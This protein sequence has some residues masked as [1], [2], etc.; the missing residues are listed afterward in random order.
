MKIQKFKNLLTQGALACILL[1]LSPAYAQQTYTVTT[2]IDT[3]PATTGSLRWAIEQVN[4]GAGQGDTIDFKIPKTDAG[5]DP[6]T[7]TW[8]IV[9]IQ[10]LDAITQQVTIDGYSQKAGSK[11]NTLDVGSNAVLTIVLNGNN[12]MT[13]DGNTTGNGLHFAPL[14]DTSVDNSIVRGLVINQWLDNGI[15]LD[16][17][18]NN[19][20]GVSI[21]GNFIGTDAS[22]AQQMA[23][24]TGVG[25]SGLVNTCFNTVIGTIAPAD[26]NIIAGSFSRNVVDAYG[27]RGGCISSS[28]NVETMIQN[29]YIGTD[30]TGSNAL[31]NT[32]VGVRLI[33]DVGDTIFGNLISGSTI[34]GIFLINCGQTLVQRNYIGTDSSGTYAIGN[35]NSG[36]RMARSLPAGATQ[37]T[38]MIEN[39]ISG[40]GAGIHIGDPGNPGSILN[41]IQGNLIGTDK[42]GTQALPNTRYG[43]ELADSQNTV[44]GSE[45]T[46]I[47]IIS[48]NL[49]GGI[50][51][52]SNNAIAN[53]ISNNLIGTDSTGLLSL[54]NNQNGIQI[55]LNGGLGGA[56]RN[57]IG[58]DPSSQSALKKNRIDLNAFQK[59]KAEHMYELPHRSRKR[60]KLKGSYTTT[61]PRVAFSKPE[62]DQKTKQVLSRPA[63]TIGLNFTAA[64]ISNSL[65]TSPVLPNQNGW[66]GPQQYILMT[67]G[68]IR[69]FDKATGL[70]DG[71]L[72]IDA[73]SFFGTGVHSDV[74]IN[75]SRFLDRWIFSNEYNDI[76][77]QVVWSDS[78]VITPETVWTFNTF[79]NAALVPQNNPAEGPA[80][81]DY[82]QLAT[83]ANAVYISV[84]TF[85][86]ALTAFLGTS[87]LI[88]P[89]SSITTGNTSPA[90]TVIPGI[91]AN[92]SEF[93]P[94]ADNFDPDAAFGYLINAAVIWISL[95]VEHCS[96]LYSSFHSGRM[97]YL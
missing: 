75:Y 22:G 7:N 18:Q 2:T 70:P 86:N 31:G 83:D 81:L 5:Y 12:Y 51:V 87:T 92:I 74:R 15:L 36:I 4:M 30:R 38:T 56:S 42:N 72:D 23:N 54:P 71:V 52:Y 44:G 76:E 33:A 8:T 50:L 62:L 16:T 28:F 90:F 3:I 59:A 57:I 49:K 6:T 20:T 96:L 32:I 65:D 13:G 26:R 80:D 19:I 11:P 17:T 69:S 34:D 53:I 61:A 78:G 45:L 48:G 35:A 64:T 9:P 29:N 85:N 84:D 14:A 24:R 27:V 25:L 91:L 40:N 55:G 41:T 66:V 67:F 1:T 73:S 94:P 63:Q 39:L 46:E 97:L 89:N 10:D 82:Q 79:S 21:V 77:L 68:I 93:T 60:R 88:I 47:N 95:S 43:I 58:P 37:G